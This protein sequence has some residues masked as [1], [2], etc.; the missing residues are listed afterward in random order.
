MNLIPDYNAQRPWSAEAVAKGLQDYLICIEMFIGAIVH[1]FVFPHTD[2]ISGGLSYSR[3]SDSISSSSTNNKIHRLGKKNILFHHHNRKRTRSPPP[4][5]KNKRNFQLELLTCD[6]AIQI[7]GYDTTKSPNILP[8][9]VV[10]SAPNPSISAP[11]LRL[12][13]RDQFDNT[14]DLQEV[15]LDDIPS[16]SSSCSSPEFDHSSGQLIENESEDNGIELPIKPEPQPT[17]FLKAFLDSTVPRDVVDNAF[18][19]VQGQFRV[20]KKT[21]LHHAATSD[22]YDVFSKEKRRKQQTKIL[23]EGTDIPIV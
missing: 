6:E 17:G 11:N 15:C 16:I 1:V 22:E 20:E 2:Y 18:G 7:S 8:K 4:S 19:A 23:L 3:S 12:H 21:L 5:R 9:R 14:L 13:K 10:K